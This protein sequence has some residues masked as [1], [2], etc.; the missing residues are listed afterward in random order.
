MQTSPLTAAI[1]AGLRQQAAARRIDRNGW[2][3]VADNPVSRAGVFE[4]QGSEL[5]GA[6]DPDRV[7]RVLRP[8]EELADP[9]CLDS[10]RLVPIIDEHTWVG[11]GATPAEQKGVHGTTGE[12]A[13]FDGEFIRTTIKIFS[14]AMAALIERGKQELSSGYACAYEWTAGVWNGEHYDAIQRNIRANHVALVTEG[15]MGPDVRV[16]DQRFSIALDSAEHKVMADTALTIE[17]MQ[18]QLAQ[19]LPVVEQVNALKEQLAASGAQVDADKE[20]ADETAEAVIKEAAD[21]EEA[22]AAVEIETADEDETEAEKILDEKEKALDE[23]VEKLEPSDKAADAAIAFG[24]A[25]ARAAKARAARKART[26]DSRIKRLESTAGDSAVAVLA[27]RDTTARRLYPHVGVF[28]HAGMTVAQVVAYGAEKLGL[29]K[30]TD[31]ATLDAFLKGRESV[32]PARVG[33]SR[34]AADDSPIGAY[35]AAAN[36]PKE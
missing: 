35:I 32:Q 28:D 36:K 34:K 19:L 7:Y 12:S 33:D 25:K 10:F 23:T 1:T 26:L 15:R 9:E 17:E 8:P 18:A 5:P 22:A 21:V 29:P 4:Y 24:K 27:Q 3:E 20:A 16:L 31:P 6:P 2:Y 14:D 30:E 11:G 13:R